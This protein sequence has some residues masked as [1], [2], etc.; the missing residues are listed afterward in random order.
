MSDVKQEKRIHV[1]RACRDV[2]RN[3]DYFTILLLPSMNQCTMI[4]HQTI[5]YIVRIECELCVAEDGMDVSC[6]NI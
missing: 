6:I 1:A 5:L 3:S 4:T 2:R